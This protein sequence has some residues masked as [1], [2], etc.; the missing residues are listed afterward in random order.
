MSSSERY[1][2][3]S[4]EVI[5][6]DQKEILLHIYTNDAAAE[7]FIINHKL[8]LVTRGIGR[9]FEV[10]LEPGIYKIKVRSGSQIK[11]ELIV[12][13]GEEAV[14]EKHFK[15]LEIASAAPIPNTAQTHEYHISNAVLHSTRSRVHVRAGEGSSIYLFARCWTSKD[16]SDYEKRT[17]NPAKG[18]SLHDEQGEL[19]V[20][21]ERR[22]SKSSD[23]GDP[24]AACLI[25]I[26][27][28]CYRLRLE[29]A[30]GTQVEQTIVAVRDWQTQ[31]FLLLRNYGNDDNPDWRA[32]LSGA[33]ILMNKT[34]EGFNAQEDLRLDELARLALIN[35]RK[36][37]SDDIQNR[38][39]HGK[40]KNPL[41]GIYGA[42]LLLM[43]EAPDS[44]L[45]NTIVDN[46]RD[47]IGEN[48]PDVEALAFRVKGESNFVC[49][50]PPM[51]RR[52][53]GIIIEKSAER[54]NLVPRNSLAERVSTRIWGA[55]PFLLWLHKS[56]AD[57]KTTAQDSLNV[58][59]DALIQRLKQPETIFSQDSA[60]EMKTAIVGK[61]LDFT[62]FMEGIVNES[63]SFIETQ[64]NDEILPR[65]V[66][67]LGL[68]RNTVEKIINEVKASDFE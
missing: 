42:H 23:K 55:E 30:D 59:K 48:H 25:G 60:D 40:F 7:I 2:K 44:N 53:W 68:P 45:L 20:D 32:D 14:V 17:E 26:N 29:M 54:L 11:E 56:A 64:L 33:S 6:E 38:L 50:I 52:S 35:N 37:L 16:Y 31:I 27:P 13:S 49:T 22:S 46:L 47:I 1:K 18:L 66:K 36:I 8:E 9:H 51:L 10:S 3:S 43:N 21:V 19:I 39:L 5:S 61:D 58:Y 28:G 41:F 62:D 24:W 4:L 63:A 34:D 65:L 67:S 15:Q 12:L 57:K